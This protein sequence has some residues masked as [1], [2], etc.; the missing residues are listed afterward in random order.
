MT[1]ASAAIARLG[2]FL[3]HAVQDFGQFMRFCAATS[4]W[5]F[6]RASA[7]FR[8]RLLGPQLFYVGIASIPVVAI[9]GAFIGMVLAL[10]GF[11]Q[12][13]QLGQEGRLGPACT[14]AS[15]SQDGTNSPAFP[16]AVRNVACSSVPSEHFAW[17]ESSCKL[18]VN[19]SREC[20][21]WCIL[22]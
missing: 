22:T 8:W 7:W 1:A 5:L 17:Y 18:L 19:A 12:F 11:Y 15:R 2:H 13:E 10:E 16:I 6:I 14:R 20:D 21:P 3:L 4:G 9:T